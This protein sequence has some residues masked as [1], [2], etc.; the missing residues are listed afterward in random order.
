MRNP[1]SNLHWVKLTSAQIQKQ[2]WLKLY[3]KTRTGKH[4]VRAATK[5]SNT[6]VNVHCSTGVVTQGVKAGS[7]YDA[8]VSVTMTYVTCVKIELCSI[9]AS[10][11]LFYM[12]HST[13]MFRKLRRSLTQRDVYH[14][15]IL[16]SRHY[17]ENG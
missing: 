17:R 1:R 6:C 5:Q 9:H 14:C 7:E 3:C 16:W 13:Y 12:R 10:R 8:S 11:T 15:V 2:S 4:S